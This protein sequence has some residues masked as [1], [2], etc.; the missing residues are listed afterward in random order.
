MSAHRWHGGLFGARALYQ[1]NELKA[2]DD[3]DLC[4]GMEERSAV[5]KI[6]HA[7]RASLWPNPSSGLLHVWIPNIGSGKQVQWRIT[8]P[9]GKV[10]QESKALS[11][12]GQLTIDASKLTSGLYFC[13]INMAGSV[14]KPLKFVIS[15]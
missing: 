13:Y 12:G 1:R 6:D 3:G 7:V 14:F 15:R 5:S 8:D 10:V 2:F 9:S 11:L 4:T